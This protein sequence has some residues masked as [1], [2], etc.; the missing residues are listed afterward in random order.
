MIGFQTTK[1]STQHSQLSTTGVEIKP[2]TNVVL[3]G[4]QEKLGCVLYD[5]EFDDVFRS[6]WNTTEY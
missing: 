2:A 6:W 3:L 4:L 5:A 1:S